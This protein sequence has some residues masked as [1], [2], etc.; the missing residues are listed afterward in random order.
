[1]TDGLPSTLSRSA[2][3]CLVER[4]RDEPH[5]W[6]HLVEHVPDRRSYAQVWRD[7]SVDVWVIAWMRDHDT[8]YHDHDL[9]A[10]AFTVVSGLLVEER[11]VLGG[12]PRR[13]VMRAGETVDF[14]ASHVHR[15]R[16]EADAPAVSLHAYSPPL[17]RMGAYTVAGDGTL[18][19]ETVS[20]A[21]ELT[22]SPAPS[23]G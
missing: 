9:S 20:Y 4:L 1:M 2:L 10:G 17:R 8:G 12:A 15:V 13:R 14:A 21:D 16:H 23:G 3:R 5:R 18:E 6:S 22:A 7:G 19:R 11:L